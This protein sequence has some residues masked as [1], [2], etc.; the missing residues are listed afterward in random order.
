MQYSSARPLVG[1]RAVLGL[2]GGEQAVV[3]HH[4]VAVRMNRSAKET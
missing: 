3:V 4:G 2:V 1:G